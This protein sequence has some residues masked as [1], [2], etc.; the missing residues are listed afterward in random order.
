MKGEFIMMEGLSLPVVW[1]IVAVIAVILE[2]CT[3]QLVS[4]WF[5]VGAV[6]AAIVSVFTDDLIVQLA[7]FSLLSI[8]CI[9]ATRPLARHL[10]SKSGDVPT[11]CDRY[12]G[13]VADVIVD[14]DDTEAVGQVK[15]EGSV[16]SAKSETGAFIPA[17]TKVRVKA[18]EGVKMVVA[19][20]EA[21]V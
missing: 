14:I 12:I 11:N 16:W 19:P 5:A 10:K 2:G 13:K 21:K 20:C 9:V 8:V 6:A 18:I 1:I 3:V 4:L 17:G 7:V 15:A